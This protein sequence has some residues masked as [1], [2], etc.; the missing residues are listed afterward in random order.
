MAGRH[1]QRSLELL[2]ERS[3]LV[4]RIGRERK[5]R[6]A[7]L[8]RT[9]IGRSLLLLL[10]KRVLENVQSLLERAHHIAS[11]I[12]LRVVGD[13]LSCGVNIQQQ[14]QSRLS[15][16]LLAQMHTNLL[17]QLLVNLLLQLKVSSLIL[18]LDLE[19][20]LLVTLCKLLLDRSRP[21][22]QKL[23]VLLL[24]VA[25]VVLECLLELH[26]KEREREAASRVRE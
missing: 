13:G 17:E 21:G 6:Q 11:A 16:G 23:S 10:G 22:G 2:L 24:D 4:E 12:G 5:D 3:R 18:I 15:A 8:L 9:E 19:H 14:Q 1:L 20:S 25:L 26:H 7:D